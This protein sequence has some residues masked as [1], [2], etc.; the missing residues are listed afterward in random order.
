MY[1]TRNRALIGRL[2]SGETEVFIGNCQIRPPEKDNSIFNVYIGENLV[3]VERIEL[4]ASRTRT[5]R[6]TDDLHSGF[7]HHLLIRPEV[8]VANL[9]SVKPQVQLVF[10][11]GFVS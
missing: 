2:K 3:G 11:L 7:K 4:S 6:S 10:R 9:G 1:L 8:I 5:E